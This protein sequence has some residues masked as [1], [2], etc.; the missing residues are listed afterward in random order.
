ML[1]YLQRLA[2]YWRHRAEDMP[3]PLLN[4]TRRVRRAVTAQE[5]A[6]LKTSADLEYNLG[7]IKKV[8]G[9]SSDLQV[10]RF[11]LGQEK[12]LPAALL[13]LESMLEGRLMDEHV[14]RPL[15]YDAPVIGLHTGQEV[16]LAL[17][18]NSLLTRSQSRWLAELA[19]A[20]DELLRGSALLLVEGE[21][22]LLSVEIKGYQVRAIQESEKEPVVRGPRDAFVEHL[23]T[24]ISLV[25]RRIHSPNL[26]V[27]KMEI[28]RVS[29]NGVVILY[30]RGLCDPQLVCYVRQ[31]LQ[32]VTVDAI[33]ESYYLEELLQDSILSP[34]PQLG[35]TERPDRAVAALLEGRLVILTDNS[36]QA[37]IAPGEFFSLLETS[38]DY[39]QNYLFATFVR[40]L[41]YAAFAV[42]LVLPSFYIA[43][44]TYHQEMIPSKLLLSI[45][46]ARQG[47]PFPALVEALTMEL[48]FEILREA[49]V[50]LPRPV[51][52][53]VSIVGALVIGQASV[54][55]GLVSALMVI[56]V[57]FTGIASF[58]VP[59]FSLGQ[60]VRI[61]RFPLMLTAA[62]LGLFG[63]M[64][65]ILVILLH[66]ASLQ[67]FGV[68]YLAPAAPLRAASLRDV[69]VRLPGSGMHRPAGR[70]E[71]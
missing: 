4:K 55:A 68:P 39:N 46:S 5:I 57:A 7:L 19:P 6:A 61:L 70:E 41:R 37:L 40:F 53:A 42:S 3:N 14:L 43:T 65:F 59:H 16:L 29:Q 31:R 25:R 48:M 69:L 1:K 8:L 33:Q 28:G 2:R 71:R 60:T 34:F 32:S 47:V 58:S 51:G 54:Q 18:R 35:N 21:M 10:R 17:Q 24:N 38:E 44:T 15:L 22:R 56:V 23:Q 66:M 63:V 52:Q 67:S 12:V 49:G 27:E 26:Q 30:I 11:Y 20:L 64:C 13:F 50:R 36:P 45:I 9:E 62:L